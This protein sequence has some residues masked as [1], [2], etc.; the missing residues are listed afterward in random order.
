MKIPDSLSERIELYR[1]LVESV[2]SDAICL[3]T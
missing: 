2:R 1:A 3:P